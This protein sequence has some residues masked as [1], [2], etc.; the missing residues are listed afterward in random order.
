MKINFDDIYDRESNKIAL[1]LAHGPSLRNDLPRIF[2]LSNNKKDF[3]TFTTGEASILENAGYFFNL[4]YWT[5]ANS[6]FTV[7]NSYTKIN[8]YDNIHSD[9]F[10]ELIDKLA[11]VHIRLWYL[12]DA[13]SLETSPEEM[14]ILKRKADI[15][16]KQKRPMLVKA[17]DKT[18]INICKGKFNQ[19]SE[20]TKLYNGFKD[21]EKVINK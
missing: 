17:I 16:F 21:D 7:Q 3:A 5:I 18:I 2:E 10:S 12:E 11:V 15:T 14:L 13:M 9:S 8:K 19:E 20:N 4:D 6:V 1:L